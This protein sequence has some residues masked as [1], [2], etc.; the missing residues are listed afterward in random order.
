MIRFIDDSHEYFNEADESYIS[1]SGIAKL[2]E[3][4]KDWEAIKKKRAKKLGVTVDSLTEDW[5]RK[6]ILGTQAGTIVHSKREKHLI[7]NPFTY[8]GV[9]LNKKVCRTKGDWKYSLIDNKLENNTVYPEA[10]IFDHELRVAGQ[11]DKVIVVN[12]TIHVEDYKTDKKMDRKAFSNEWVSAEKLLPPVSHLD[13]CE[14]SMYSLKMSMYMYLLWKKNKHL[15]VGNLILEWLQLERDEDTI[16][17]LD[18]NGHPIVKKIERI[19]VPYLRKE[20][21]DIFDWYKQG[22]LTN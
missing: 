1:V 4:K 21:K 12:N 2:L 6:K 10:M 18:E 9:S 15:K 7:E 19:E 13:N 11:S 16:P 22:K 8:Q 17:V 14:F 20:V 5:N 3:Q